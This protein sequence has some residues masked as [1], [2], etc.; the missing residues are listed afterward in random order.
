MTKRSIA[1]AKQYAVLKGWCHK[2]YLDIRLS[3]LTFTF[4][5]PP[6]LH[7]VIK[8]EVGIILPTRRCIWRGTALVSPSEPI[9]SGI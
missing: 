6:M 3:G 4:L 1:T 7:I 2:W 5:S 8:Y 9:Q